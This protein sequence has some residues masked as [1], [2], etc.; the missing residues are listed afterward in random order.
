VISLTEMAD[1]VWPEKVPAFF[2]PPSSTL[3]L[4]SDSD[5]WVRSYGQ[6]NLLANAAPTEP[7]W[8]FFGSSSASVHRPH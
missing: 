4:T 7:R 2:K 6:P 5:E 8:D 3:S 1:G